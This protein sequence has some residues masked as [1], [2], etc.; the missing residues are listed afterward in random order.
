M[1]TKKKIGEPVANEWER[2]NIDISAT[3]KVDSVFSVDLT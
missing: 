3:S 1:T 2:K